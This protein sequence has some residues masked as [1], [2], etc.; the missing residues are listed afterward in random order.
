[1]QER[2]VAHPCVYRARATGLGTLRLH[3]AGV[4][5]AFFGICPV[6]TATVVDEG[7]I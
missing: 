3:E 5:Q 2:T 1:M 4:E 7:R 6:P